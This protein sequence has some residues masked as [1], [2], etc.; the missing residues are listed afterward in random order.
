MDNHNYGNNNSNWGSQTYQSM[1]KE[2]V[3][4]STRAFIWGIISICLA[5][6]CFCYGQF[7]ALFTSVIGLILANSAIKK[8]NA[9]PGL[10]DVKSFKKAK[11]GRILSIIGLCIAVVMV[12]FFMVLRILDFPF[13]LE[14][15]FEKNK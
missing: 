2:P 1:G 9:D 10:Y 14:N 5:P 7:P 8:Y 15:L 12:G 6:T 13:K 11:T 3:P 4:N